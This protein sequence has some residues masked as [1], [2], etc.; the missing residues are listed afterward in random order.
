MGVGGDKATDAAI[1]IYSLSIVTAGLTYEGKYLTT[2]AVLCGIWLFESVYVLCGFLKARSAWKWQHEQDAPFP[3]KILWTIAQT[4]FLMQT[5]I[6]YYI[7]ISGF[8]A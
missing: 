4:F 7:P 8:G 5:S 2:A 6:A 3:G 1:R